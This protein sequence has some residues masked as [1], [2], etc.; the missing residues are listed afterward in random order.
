MKGSI[1]FV[2]LLVVIFIGSILLV[3]G[4]Y[5]K[6]NYDALN[7]E[8]QRTFEQD[9][10][11]TPTGRQKKL[12]L[13][14]SELKD[15]SETLAIEF[16]LDNSATMGDEGKIQSLK[17]S[18]TFFADK[19]KDKS[20][21]SIRTFNSSTSLLVGFD[22]YK[23][24]K[25][26]VYSVIQNLTPGGGT[27]MRDAFTAAKQDLETALQN[28]QQNGYIFNLIFFSDGIPETKK[29]NKNG[30]GLCSDTQQWG[31]RCFDQEQDPTNTN[32]QGGN[33]TE[34]IKNLKNKDKKKVRVFSIFLFNPVDDKPFKK[35]AE[36]LMKNIASTGD[37]YTTPRQEDLQDIFQ[38]IAIKVCEQ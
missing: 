25:S 30:V 27:Y 10:G 19:L 28:K 24:N 38:E 18:L 8:N 34:Y 3:G 16:L 2:V 12:Q 35:E 4:P 20:L 7:L 13:Q 37:F 32:L 33:L 14:I 6:L 23:N 36:T 5:P 17:N 29:A 22:Q 11:P 31:T 9:D 21:I 15:C 26:Q 1:T